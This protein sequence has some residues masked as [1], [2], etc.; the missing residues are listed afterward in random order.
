MTITQHPSP[1]FDNNRLPITTI[2][3]HWIVGTLAMA[4]GVFAKPNGTSAHY[5]VENDQ[6]HQYVQ[7]NKVAYHA[8]NY[9]M[10]QRSI[11]IEHSAAPD[12]PASEATYQTSGQLIAQ[13]A[14]KYGIPLDR[15]HILRHGEVIPTQCCGTVDVDKLISNAKSVTSSPQPMNND[16]RK[17]G[18]FNLIVNALFAAHKLGTDNSDALLDNDP[19]LGAVKNLL[20]ENED[21]KKSGTSTLKKEIEA[22]LVKY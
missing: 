2:V 7:E 4:D 21:L 22:V 3:C 20:K 16:S 1:N 19:V 8:G 14:K 11:G 5:G 17:A 15:G 18:Q 13:I 6:V 10:N 9:P 12:R